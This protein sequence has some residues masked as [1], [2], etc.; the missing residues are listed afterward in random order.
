MPTPEPKTQAEIFG[1][2]LMEIRNSTAL[3]RVSLA[4]AK[5]VFS[6]MEALGYR[7]MKVAD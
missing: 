3:G 6:R 5:E 2:L 7:V 4:E 1:D